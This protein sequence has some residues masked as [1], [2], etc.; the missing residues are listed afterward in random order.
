MRQSGEMLG[1]HA[2][3]VPLSVLHTG[4]AALPAHCES[5]A[6][7]VHDLSA[8][9]QKKPVS[10]SVLTTHGFAQTPPELHG[11]AAGQV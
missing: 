7:S 10:Q 9:L 8:E 4:L 11:Y 5:N 6:H 2:A 1:E 3:Q